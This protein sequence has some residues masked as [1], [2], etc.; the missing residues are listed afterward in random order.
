MKDIIKKALS[1]RF[2]SKKFDDSQKL[3]QD[4]V[5]LILES[6]NLAPTSYGIQPFQII[7]VTNQELKDAISKAGWNQ[8]Q[9]STCDRLL[10]WATENDMSK[11]L[12]NY[13][14]RIIKY[15]RQEAEAAAG[16]IGFIQNSLDSTQKRHETLDQWNAKQ[17]YISLGFALYTCALLGVESAPMEG[18]DPSAVDEILGL[19]KLGLKSVVILTIGVGT[20][21]DANSTNPKVRKSIDELVIKT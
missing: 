1:T 15:Q 12:E 16:F 20:T 4:Q 21:D 17:A 7:E 5:D 14:S 19:T 13:K 6:A 11:A 3:S 2:T 9:F 10:V 18:F 8:E